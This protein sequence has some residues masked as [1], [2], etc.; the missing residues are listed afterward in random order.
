MCRVSGGEE[1]NENHENHFRP[2]VLREMEPVQL[3]D[4]VGRDYIFVSVH[5]VSEAGSACLHVL[6]W[7]ELHAQMQCP[8]TR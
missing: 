7:S 5:D 8:R 6:V 4:L 3:A 1:D 2:Q